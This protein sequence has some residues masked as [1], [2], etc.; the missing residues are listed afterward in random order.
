MR[1]HCATS[2]RSLLAASN[3]APPSYQDGALPDELK[4]HGWDAWIR[5]TTARAKTWRPAVSRHPIA[6]LETDSNRRPVLYKRTA[7]AFLSYRGMGLSGLQTLSCY[8]GFTQAEIPTPRSSRSHNA[9]GGTTRRIVLPCARRDS[10]PQRP[11]SRAGPSAMLGYEHMEPLDGLEP[12]ACAL[13]G[14]RSAR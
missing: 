14:R 13:R 10:N 9:E 6:S 4:R 3:R 12:P 1:C 5:T 11:A 7:R 2:A 8:R